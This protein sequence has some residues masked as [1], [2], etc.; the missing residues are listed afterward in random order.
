M[1]LCYLTR[2]VFFEPSYNENNNCVD[3]TMKEI[4]IAFRW[5]KPAIISSHRVNYVGRIDENNRANGLN[6]LNL[7]LKAIL[8]KWPDVEFMSTNE[9]GV[10]ITKDHSSK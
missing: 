1:G 3:D 7:L 10:L 4:E 9:L 2:N 5:R 6:Q 8:K